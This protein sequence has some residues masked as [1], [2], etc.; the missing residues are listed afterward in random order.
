MRLILFPDVIGDSYGRTVGG[1]L[2]VGPTEAF[3]SKR[4]S[5]VLN[6]MSQSV[7]KFCFLGLV[8]A[9]VFLPVCACLS[10]K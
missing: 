1:R 8:I 5:A 4:D 2:L 3:F 9:T 7:R 6:E 10:Q